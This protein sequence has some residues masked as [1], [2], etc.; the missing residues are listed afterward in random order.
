VQRI[1]RWA[2]EK[3]RFC[4]SGKPL[5]QPLGVCPAT[6]GVSMSELKILSLGWGI[7]S[8][9]MAA[10]IALGEL[11]PVDFAV[12]SNTTWDRESTYD[13]EKQH[14]QWLV[15]HGINVVTV[16]AENPQPVTDGGIVVIPAFNTP[17]D[18]GHSQ[19]RRRC[20][21]D[22]KIKPLRDFI[23][24]ELERRNIDKTPAVVEQWLG[25]SF[26]EFQRAK[27][28][29]V[30]Y[31]LHRYPLLEKKM[32]R[33]DCIQWLIKNNLPSPGKSSCTFCPY[34]SM[35]EWKRIKRAGGNDWSTVI[36]ID[37]KI[38]SNALPGTYPNF[39]HPS[40][41]PVNNAVRIPED[42]GY[43]QRDLFDTSDTVDSDTPCDS[44][45]CFM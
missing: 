4:E 15:E 19:I 22:W 12:H 2:R 34:H 25:I 44:G 24:A 16:R 6:K 26:D 27:D 8:W 1:C 29:D 23:R 43:V 42:D 17:T 38:R 5:T 7:Q 36:Q 35:D 10:M 14:T 30:K 20:T 9:T 3:S 41:K 21:N 33:N 13:F 11:E 45:Y 18:K 28:A 32:T 31:I 37:E 40:C 39:V